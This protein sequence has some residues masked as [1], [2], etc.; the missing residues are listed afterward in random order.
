MH[1]SSHLRVTVHIKNQLR[2]RFANWQ[3]WPLAATVLRTGLILT[4]G[5]P[6]QVHGRIPC[7]FVGFSDRTC[8]VVHASFSSI[9]G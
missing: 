2:F 3:L 8:T 7:V 5:H 6:L 9:E 4:T 1:Y